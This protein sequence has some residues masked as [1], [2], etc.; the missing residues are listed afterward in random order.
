MERKSSTQRGAFFTY[1]PIVREKLLEDGT[2]FEHLLTPDS[3]KF[4]VEFDWN[5]K[6]SHSLKH[7]K[8]VFINKRNCFFSKLTLFF[9]QSRQK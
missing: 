4:A 3:S 8:V 2:E 1:L 5:V 9:F 6:N 7:T